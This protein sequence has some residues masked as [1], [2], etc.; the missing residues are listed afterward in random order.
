MKDMNMGEYIKAVYNLPTEL[1]NELFESLKDAL[2]DEEI[3]TIK[4]VVAYYDMFTNPTK[5]KAMRSAICEEL[6]GM[7]VPFSVKTQFEL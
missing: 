6:F 1:Q 4:Q 2:T 3:A 5:Y 7:T